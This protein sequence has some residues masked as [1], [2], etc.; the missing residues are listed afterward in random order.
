ML[1]THMVEIPLTYK[2]DIK[3]GIVSM[4]FKSV[5]EPKVLEI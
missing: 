2:F 3:T 4:P 1:K 5:L